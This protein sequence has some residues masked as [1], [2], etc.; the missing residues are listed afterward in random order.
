M[1]RLCVQKEVVLPN[2]TLMEAFPE[3]V[4]TSEAG[5]HTQGTGVLTHS[6]VVC[7]AVG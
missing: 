4:L 5:V 2:L 3:D 7:V 6:C 1:L